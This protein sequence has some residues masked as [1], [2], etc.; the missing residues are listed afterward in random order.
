M[1]HAGIGRPVI[2][3]RTSFRPHSSKLVLPDFYSKML[4]PFR[5]LPIPHRIPDKLSGG[6]NMSAALEDYG[7]I[8][9]CETAALVGRTGSIDGLLWPRFDSDACFAALLGTPKNGRWTLAPAS[10]QKNTTRKYREHTLILET[11][12]ERGSASFPSEH[13]RHAY[14]HRCLNNRINRAWV[15]G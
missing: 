14:R 5:T 3:R 6:G 11:R 2:T 13:G 4:H 10:A 7:M 9:D 1:T 8:G 12:F 15:V